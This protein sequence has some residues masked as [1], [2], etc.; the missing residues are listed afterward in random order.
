MDI[1]IKW[2]TIKAF[3]CNMIKVAVILIQTARR[4]TIHR[5][6]QCHS[7]KDMHKLRSIHRARLTFNRLV[8]P[9]TDFWLFKF[10]A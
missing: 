7:I 8:K 3:Q 5:G 1:R 9:C 10:R 2:H 6:T 4:C